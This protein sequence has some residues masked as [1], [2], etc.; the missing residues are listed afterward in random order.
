MSWPT[1]QDYNEALQNPSLSFTDTDLR[2]GHPAL[3][4]F[5]LPRPITG[6][7][8]SVYRLNSIGADWAV[9]CFLRNIPDQAKRYQEISK[10][11]DKA[12]LPYTVDFHYLDQGIKTHGQWYP[13]LK[14]QWVE[15]VTLTNFI[16]RN[17][18]NSALM[19]TL[20][21]HFKKMM[22]LLRDNGIA[23]GDLQH[24]NILV[25]DND[26]KLVDYDGMY[27]PAFAGM[28]ATELGNRNYQHPGRTEAFLGPDLDNFSAWVIYTSLQCLSIDPALWMKLRGGDECLLFRQQDFKYPLSSHA[29]ALL[30]AHNSETVRQGAKLLRSFA[31]GPLKD[32]PD[33]DYVQTEPLNLPPIQEGTDLPGWLSSAPHLSD[34]RHPGYTSFKEY[35]AQHAPHVK[36]PGTSAAAYP[37]QAAASSQSSPLPG[38]HPVSP[39]VYNYAGT[40]SNPSSGFGF[41]AY[42]SMFSFIFV[43]V[44]YLLGIGIS[45]ILPHHGDTNGPEP[46]VEQTKSQTPGQHY[47]DQASK[48]FDQRNYAAAA[49]L[50][51]SAMNSFTYEAGSAGQNYAW[52]QY[53]L[54]CCNLYMKHYSDAVSTLAD[55]LTNYQKIDGYDYLKSA[56]IMTALGAA[57]LYSGYTT[58]AI[59]QYNYALGIYSN[60][61]P[62][63]DLRIAIADSNLGLAFNRAKQY[64]QAETHL[65]HALTIYVDR[66]DVSGK[67]NV[68]K[69]LAYNYRHT[70]KTAQLKEAETEIH[71]LMNKAAK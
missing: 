30:E 71:A 3:T 35:T 37:Q 17:L 6:N 23:H 70:N 16:E 38:P 66:K 8:A 10:Q 13:V 58:D 24:G 31:L 46:T 55:A 9:R 20:A 69:E 33:L 48:Y 29:F 25:R 32:V 5:G 59:E 54:G 36:Q 68:L 51:K 40:S 15:G 26:F 39:V 67:L 27:V 12:H 2:T 21:E 62:A 42:A 22:S 50:F 4:S 28:K 57:Y 18:D 53:M 44:V 11:L 47:Y 56:D 41:R 7:F 64:S 14:M 45:T 52:S 34:T 65:K 19:G 49:P 63:G 60:N 1:P 61:L 43:C